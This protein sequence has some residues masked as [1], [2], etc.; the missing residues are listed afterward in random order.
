MDTLKLQCR[1]FVRHHKMLA[2]AWWL[3]H[4]REDFPDELGDWFGGGP[5]ESHSGTSGSG[6][7]D[8]TRRHAGGTRTR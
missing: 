4:G 6:W 1:D 2:I 5:L 3:L 7:A 8:P